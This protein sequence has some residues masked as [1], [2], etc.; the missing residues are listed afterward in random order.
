MEFLCPHGNSNLGRSLKGLRPDP[1]INKHNLDLPEITPAG[2]EHRR[3]SSP[4][5]NVTLVSI[6]NIQALINILVLAI[7]GW[8]IKIIGTCL[9]DHLFLEQAD[10]DRVR[11]LLALGA[12]V[13]A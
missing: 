3:V 4:F 10:A 9:R 6:Y 12:S 5:T 2:S 7:I 13:T 1:P 8:T 11:Q